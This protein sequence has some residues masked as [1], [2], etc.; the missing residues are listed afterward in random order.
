MSLSAICLRGMLSTG[1]TVI[2]HMAPDVENNQNNQD[3]QNDHV[4]AVE[5]QAQRIQMIAEDSTDIC[6]SQ[7]PG[8]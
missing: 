8:K 7:A 4:Q 1:T 5:D 3:N 6:Q 2:A